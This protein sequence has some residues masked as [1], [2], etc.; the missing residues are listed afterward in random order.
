VG[1]RLIDSPFDFFRVVEVFASIEQKAVRAGDAQ[2]T[3]SVLQTAASRAAE[4]KSVAS[5][6]PHRKLDTLLAVR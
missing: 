4:E 1:G 3:L 6:S 2:T 5:R